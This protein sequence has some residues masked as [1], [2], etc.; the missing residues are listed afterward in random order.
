MTSWKADTK[1][2]WVVTKGERVVLYTRPTGYSTVDSPDAVTI[3]SIILEQ[4][5]AIDFVNKALNTNFHSKVKIY[6]YN[7]DEAREK[8]GT[9]GG[10]F[11]SLNKFKK[12]IYF[13]FHPQPY[14]NT[15]MDKFDNVGVHEMV[16]IITIS[17]LG[18]IRTGF[19]GEGYANAIDGNYGVEY[20]DG[21]PTRKR[22]DA[23]LIKI[24]EAGGL[25][26][27]S[28]LLYNDFIPES[29]YYPQIGCLIK[30][31]FEEYG[32]NNINKLFG[33]KRDRIEQEFKRITGVDFRDMEAKYM[34]YVGLHVD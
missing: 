31:M 22:N 6:L 32:V 13:T 14:F 3:Q 19:F 1:G 10:G 12:H 25:L 15:V 20:T 29:A 2:P 24:R 28:D 18:R 34:T 11:A 21:I 30:W 7:K 4:E 26:S 9:D 8:I 33:L 16:H 5:Q 17:K 27:P 23:A